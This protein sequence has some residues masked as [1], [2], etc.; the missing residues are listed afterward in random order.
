MILW[1]QRS[2]KATNSFMDVPGRTILSQMRVKE[3]H[4]KRCKLLRSS[5]STFEKGDKMD[6]E[7]DGAGRK[8]SS[9]IYH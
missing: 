4:P 6:K 1:E 5:M 2:K 7:H 8:D 3:G 9:E